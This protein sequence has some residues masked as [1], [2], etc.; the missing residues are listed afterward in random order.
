MN[1]PLALTAAALTLLVATSAGSATAGALITS[2][3]IKN[4]T[5]KPADLS[6]QL[7]TTATAPTGF[8]D[9]TTVTSAP[10]AGRADCPTGTHLTGGGVHSPANA[11]VVTSRPEGNSWIARTP[12][13]TF[14]QTLTIY[15]LC[16]S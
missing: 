2:K 12:N 7:R 16:A 1:K 6:K 4:G 10:G 9:V 14:D 11:A 3:H 5:I 8:T 15:A 13:P